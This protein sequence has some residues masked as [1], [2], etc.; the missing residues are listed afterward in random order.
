MSGEALPCGHYIPGEAPEP[1]LARILPFL[2][3][4]STGTRYV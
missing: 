1:L 4:P 2:L 3:Q